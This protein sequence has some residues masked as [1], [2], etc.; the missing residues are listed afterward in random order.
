M[1]WTDYTLTMAEIL[2][3]PCALITIILIMAAVHMIRD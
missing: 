3:W 2:A 1:S